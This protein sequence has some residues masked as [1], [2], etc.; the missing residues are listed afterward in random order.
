M[1][2][3]RPEHC[4]RFSTQLR[5]SER[6]RAPRVETGLKTSQH[7]K[8][9]LL[10]SRSLVGSTTIDYGSCDVRSTIEVKIGQWAIS[11][12]ANDSRMVRGC[13][14]VDEISKKIIRL[15][16]YNAIKSV[17]A[18]GYATGFVKKRC[19]CPC[20]WNRFDFFVGFFRID[21]LKAI[22]N[23]YSMNSFVWGL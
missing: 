19:P 3:T 16:Y 22:L 18:V 17:Y 2:T 20:F 8:R 7:K 1:Y 12:N 13:S 5:A 15:T 14:K 4:P 11:N 23:R 10:S 6:S 21:Q 9:V